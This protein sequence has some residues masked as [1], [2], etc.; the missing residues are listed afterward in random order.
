MT[1]FFT[2]F[3]SCGITEPACLPALPVPAKGI[4]FPLSGTLT[5]GVLTSLSPFRT[6]PAPAPAD[7]ANRRTFT[8]LTEELTAY[9]TGQLQTFTVPLEDHGTPC[10]RSVWAALR[11]IPYGQ[12]R[13]YGEI[14]AILGYTNPIAARSVGNACG[15]N[16]ILILT[17]CHRVFAKGSIGG[18]SGAPELKRWLCALENIYVP[19]EVSPQASLPVR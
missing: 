4:P 12:S 19:G 9:F 16:P 10:Q 1:E 6:I 18:F 5:D 17:P 14:A 15:R 2:L 8:R 11:Q 7:P 13:T 3:P